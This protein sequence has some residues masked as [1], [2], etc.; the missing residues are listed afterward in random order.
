[1]ANSTSKNIKAKLK[2]VKALAEKGEKGERET[3]KKMLK[4]L[5]EK[6]SNIKLKEKKL[7]KRTFKL[8]D[9][10]DCKTIMVHCI[11]NANPDASIE[12]N[13]RRKEL[14]VRLTN[15]EYSNVVFTFNHYYPIYASQ[16][17]SFLIAFILKNNLGVSK[18]QDV[19]DN[20]EDVNEIIGIMA[21]L[22]AVPYPN[23]KTLN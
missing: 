17:S 9:F 11:L 4:D 10:E 14:Y 23:L 19:G 3:A 5:T 2:K 1:M 8:A 13:L 21:N 6:Y 15:E 20:N 22:K 7:R 16:K 12:G 18:G